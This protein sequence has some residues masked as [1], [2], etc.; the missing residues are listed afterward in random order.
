MPFGASSPSPPSGMYLASG[1]NNGQCMGQYSTNTENGLGALNT[2]IV[3]VPPQTDARRWDWLHAAAEERR[4]VAVTCAA[5]SAGQRLLVQA[6]PAGI[7][8][9]DRVPTDQ[10]LCPQGTDCQ[11][12]LPAGAY[13]VVVWSEAARLGSAEIDLSGATSGSVSL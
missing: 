12:V 4:T 5:C 8:V 10:A 2:V 13:Q 1:P 6:F 7:D 3:H 11:L 9:A